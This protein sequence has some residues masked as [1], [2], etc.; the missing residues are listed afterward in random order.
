MSRRTLY[1]LLIQTVCALSL[2]APFLAA[3]AVSMAD[4][5]ITYSSLL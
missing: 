2:H 5:V 1:R 4:Y 3:A